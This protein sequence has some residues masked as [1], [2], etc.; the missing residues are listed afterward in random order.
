M[1]LSLLLVLAL[2]GCWRG[3]VEAAEEPAPARVT[4]ATC[5]EASANAQRVIAASEDRDLAARA[6]PL[7]EIVRRRCGVDGWSME[8][9]RCVTGAPVFADLDGCEKLATEPQRAKLQRDI[10]VF[11]IAEDQQ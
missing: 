3:G 11:E 6:A 10:E 4:G 1:R 5:D 7:A 8:L 2:A 9:R